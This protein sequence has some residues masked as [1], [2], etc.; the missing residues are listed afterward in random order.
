MYFVSRECKIFTCICFSL[1]LHQLSLSAPWK[2]N[3]T[4]I[5]KVSIRVWVEIVLAIIITIHTRTC[6]RRRPSSP[7]V[8]FNGQ[9]FI[10]SEREARTPTGAIFYHLPS[11]SMWR[12]KD[13]PL[14]LVIEWF[15]L[16]LTTFTSTTCPSAAAATA[17]CSSC[18]S[19][20]S[21]QI[22]SMNVCEWRE[23]ER[24]ETFSSFGLH[25]SPL[26]STELILDLNCVIVFALAPSWW[27]VQ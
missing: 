26:C 7:R 20:E 16:M 15:S 12:K 25:L 22:V 8:K 1:F 2:L 4:W 14:G 21:L 24:E 27:V 23:R 10:Q 11:I 18:F 13:F 5:G 19:C 9:T 3:A 17:A 6:T